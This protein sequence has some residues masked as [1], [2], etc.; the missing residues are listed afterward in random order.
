MEISFIAKINVQINIF[1]TLLTI[2][3][4]SFKV[5]LIGQLLLIRSAHISPIIMVGPPRF[6]FV[7]NGKILASAILSPF[8]P[9]TLCF[10]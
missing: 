9:I 3:V 1:Y 7:I 2:V 8:V 4:V 5:S 10:K 6:A